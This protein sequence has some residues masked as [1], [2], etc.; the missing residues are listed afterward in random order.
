MKRVEYM[1]MPRL[2]ALSEV[3]WAKPVLK[4]SIDEFY[5]KLPLQLKRMDK[6]G[7]NYRIPDLYGF[8]EV[9]AFIGQTDLVVKSLLPGTIIRYTTDGQ[10][11][12]LSSPLYTGHLKLTKTTD[13]TF[14]TFRPDGS[15]SDV[16]KARF[17]KSDFAPAVEAAGNLNPGLNVVW[18]DYKGKA[19][20]EID[21]ALVKGEYCI[22][23]VSI[24]EEVKG[25]IGLIVK[26]YLQ[27]PADGIYTFALT[28]DDGSVMNL[29]G[30]LLVDNDGAHSPKEVIAQKALKKGLHPLEIRYFDSN[31]GLLKLELI[32][33][34]GEREPLEGQWLVH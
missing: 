11:P 29:D 33:S 10:M 13:L 18:L 34:K 4:P 26:G 20:A 5:K 25:N 17:V 28:S 12:N 6:M 24:P 1:L 21:T 3:G 14:R 30:E 22:Q 2:M 32:N 23:R 7:I 9:N 15:P 8:Y 19:C 31:G 16:V 27:V